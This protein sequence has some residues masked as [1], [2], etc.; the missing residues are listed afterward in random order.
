MSR[1]ELII[2]RLAVFLGSRYGALL[3]VLLVTLGLY[4]F[5]GDL[6]PV[7]WLIDLSMLLIV[8]SALRALSGRRWVFSFILAVGL[9]AAVTGAMARSLALN[10]L[11]PAGAG[12]RGL[13]FFSMVAVIFR[14]IFRRERVDMDAVLGASCAYLLYG[15]AWGS[16]YSLLE[17]WSPGSFVFVEMPSALVERFGS[18]STEGELLY[19]SLVTM[20]T[21]GY[22]DI[23]PLSPPA[24]MFAALEG[25]LA[26][27]YIAIIIARLVGLELAHRM[28][29]TP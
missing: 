23:T 5:S 6:R 24:R 3:V 4:P 12:L 13:L 1:N 25:L 22:G 20:T 18:L 26:Q 28:R 11:L 21:I 15:L 29:S 16:V 27:L 19:F 10:Q 14:D 2:D 9:G 17:W 7:K 8:G